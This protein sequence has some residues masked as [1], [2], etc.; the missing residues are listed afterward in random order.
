MLQG[1]TLYRTEIFIIGA[2]I[3]LNLLF[4]YIF[5]SLFNHK[6]KLSAATTTT[7]TTCDVAADLLSEN[8]NS[9]L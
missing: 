9:Q 4:A 3:I 6:R 7:T 1:V 8:T 2:V 5:Y